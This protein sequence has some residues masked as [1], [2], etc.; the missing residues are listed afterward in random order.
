MFEIESGVGVGDKV[1]IGVGVL[2]TLI[3]TFG[4]TTGV[5]V[6]D[7]EGDSNTMA[8]GDAVE[9]STGLFV[10]VADQGNILV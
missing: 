8:E 4:M 10:L 1:G 2:S 3:L 6:G 9:V 5:I 7:G